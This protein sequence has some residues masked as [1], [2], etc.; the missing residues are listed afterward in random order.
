M[1]PMRQKVKYLTRG[2]K[3]SLKNALDAPSPPRKWM[4]I[5]VHLTIC[6]IIFWLMMQS[7]VK[8]IEK[9]NWEASRQWAAGAFGVPLCYLIIILISSRVCKLFQRSKR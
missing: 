9:D 8:E 1:N 6:G 5:F 2:I 3:D 7:A 4:R